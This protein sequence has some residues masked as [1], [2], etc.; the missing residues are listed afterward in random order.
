MK[1]TLSL[2]LIYG[3]RL[4]E[5]AFF[6]EEFT[7]RCFKQLNGSM[8]F[9]DSTSNFGFENEQGNLLSS[10]EELRKI[11]DHYGG[12]EGKEIEI[13]WAI[14]KY[15]KVVRRWTAFLIHMSYIEFYL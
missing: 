6:V 15:L 14:R 4:K 3:I 12:L 9:T 8:N 1:R 10:F 13:R 7:I 5:V 11:V 2:P